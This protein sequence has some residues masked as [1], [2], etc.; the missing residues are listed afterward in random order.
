MSQKIIVGICINCKCLLE[1]FEMK[2]GYNECLSCRNPIEEY[3]EDL[4]DSSGD[5]WEIDPDMGCH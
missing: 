3:E 4:N 1:P 2:G 5:D